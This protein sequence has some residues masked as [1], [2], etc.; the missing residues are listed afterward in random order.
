MAAPFRWLQC[1]ACA[2]AWKVLSEAN[3]RCPNCS[4]A[5][6]VVRGG[7]FTVQLGRPTPDTATLSDRDGRDG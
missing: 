7:G 3:E 2:H 1:P 4:S 5:H 6:G